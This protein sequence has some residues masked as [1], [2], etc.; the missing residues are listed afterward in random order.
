MSCTV[1]PSNIP[2]NQG[3]LRTE[4]AALSVVRGGGITDVMAALSAPVEVLVL[5]VAEAVGAFATPVAA[6]VVRTPLPKLLALFKFG[7]N[8]SS[9]GLVAALVVGDTLPAMRA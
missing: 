1:V 2:S 8:W 4:T 7:S 5:R 3:A 6:E 9:R